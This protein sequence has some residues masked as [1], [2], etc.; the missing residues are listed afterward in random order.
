MQAHAR[1]QAG[2][3][4][5]AQVAVHQQIGHAWLGMNAEGGAL[6]QTNLTLLAAFKAVLAQVLERL[7]ILQ[8]QADRRRRAGLE[9]FFVV[10]VGV[11]AV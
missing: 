4:H 3:V 6:D 9:Q 11:D 1:A 5:N 8:R 2:H 10:L 7:F